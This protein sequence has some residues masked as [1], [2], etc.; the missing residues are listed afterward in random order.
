[1]RVPVALA[2]ILL[3]ASCASSPRPRAIDSVIAEPLLPPGVVIEALP[4]PPAPSGRTA[5]FDTS[6]LAALK[7]LPEVDA[8]PFRLAEPVQIIEVPP[9]AAPARLTLLPALPA[10]VP[11]SIALQPVAVA[12]RPVPAPLPIRIAEP[13]P[14]IP[15]FRPDA[16]SARLAVLPAPFAPV[17]EPVAILP[18][19]I[20]LRPQPTP[21][22][23][24]MAD[25]PAVM[26][27]AYPVRPLT[28]GA[29]CRLGDMSACIMAQAE[30]PNRGP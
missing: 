21:P 23:R 26:P 25:R 27:A 12:P 29:A 15:E 22:T 8:S 6:R 9:E 18:N 1:M 2:T 14:Q 10:P 16:P 17:P 20:V 24:T 19:T 13:L 4:E 30:G 28:W 5:P 7:P 3:I 11:D